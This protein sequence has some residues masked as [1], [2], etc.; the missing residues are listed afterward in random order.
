MIQL[1]VIPLNKVNNKTIYCLYS[2]DPI[3]KKIRSYLYDSANST[4]HLPTKY[5]LR[6][7]RENLTN[8]FLL[9]TLSFL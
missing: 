1:F 3:E 8:F 6:K 4:G 9:S 7:R 5:S 2:L